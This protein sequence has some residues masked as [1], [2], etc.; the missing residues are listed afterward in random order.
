MSRRMTG[1]QNITFSITPFLGQ[2]T[3]EAGGRKVSCETL[4]GVKIG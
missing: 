2:E 4:R 1:Q 3:G